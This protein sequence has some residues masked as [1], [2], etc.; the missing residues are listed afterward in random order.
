MVAFEAVRM[1][2]SEMKNE[3]AKAGKGWKRRRVKPL[4]SNAKTIQKL[5]VFH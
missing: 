5:N 3:E 1:S 2:A 4:G